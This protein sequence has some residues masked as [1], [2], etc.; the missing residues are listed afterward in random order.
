MQTFEARIPTEHGPD[1]IAEGSWG[2]G[3]H[4]L[5]TLDGERVF[6]EAYGWTA[7]TVAFMAQEQWY[8]MMKDWLS[9]MKACGSLRK[10]QDLEG[11]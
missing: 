7:G 4:E 10:Y 11:M 2:E 8:A 3:L 5:R 6:P 1:L 9:D